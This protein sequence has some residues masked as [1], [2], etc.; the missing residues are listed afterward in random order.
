M[1]VA[2]ITGITGQDGLHLTKF[3]LAKGYKVF[4]LYSSRDVSEFSKKF[5]TVSLIQGN[6]SNFSSLVRAIE[7]SNP[8]EI[9]NLAGI[10]LVSLSY[11]NPDLV[12]D[13]NGK[14]PVRLIEAIRYLGK[15][16]QIRLYQAS[17]SEMFGK[18]Q[19][20]P[21]NEDSKFNPVS[22]YGKSKTYAH[23]ACTKYRTDFG[24]HI[25]CGIL[26]NHESE[27]RSVDFVTRKITKGLAQILKGELD[28]IHL[29]S[30]DSIRDWGY[31]G[32][33]IEAMWLMLQEQIPGDYVIASGEA[34]SVKEFL[35]I[36]FLHSGLGGPVENYIV[37]DENLKRNLDVGNLIGD[38][39]KAK[40]LLGWEPKVTFNELVV[41][42][43]KHDLSF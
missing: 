42:M 27:V 41:K 18:T 35:E 12:H 4:G 17:S 28:K 26:Y 1:K 7:I 15:E 23:Q 11:L 30:L 37:I 3:L 10:S 19:D 24:M 38:S 43:M 33:Y 34:H 5:P 29:G 2:L 21:Q 39:T 31:A 16:N 14:G 6:L 20:A 32:D 13:V 40:K 36:A 9:Y 25:S 22:P 8:N